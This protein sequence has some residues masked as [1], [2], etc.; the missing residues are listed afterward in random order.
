MTFSLFC[1]GCKWF[2]HTQLSYFWGGAVI[3]NVP[4]IAFCKSC[5]PK[6]FFVP[7][8]EFN[9]HKNL[10]LTLSNTIKRGFSIFLCVFVVQRVEKQKK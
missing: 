1:F 8:F 9:F 2:L 10:F 3:S 6:L 5:V 4:K 7:C